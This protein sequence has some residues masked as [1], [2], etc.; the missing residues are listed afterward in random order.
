LVIAC[1][2]APTGKAWI[3]IGNEGTIDL[4]ATP[5]AMLFGF[6]NHNL[7][8]A[9]PAGTT[10]LMLGGDVRFWISG[11]QLDDLPFLIFGN[12]RNP[13]LFPI[14]PGC[15]LLVTADITVP[16]AAWSYQ[17]VPMAG[18]NGQLFAQGAILRPQAMFLAPAGLFATQRVAIA[19]Q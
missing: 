8:V 11:Q 2:A 7:T 6:A 3:D 9:M 1:A 10:E 15:N 18:L 19:L 5:G 12:N 4:L 14:T 16:M 13:Q 17:H